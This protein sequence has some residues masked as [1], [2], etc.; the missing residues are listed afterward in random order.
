MPHAI[1][2]FRPRGYP[3]VRHSPSHIN[4]G[5]AH[6]QW[7]IQVL[8]RNPVCQCGQPATQAHHIKALVDGGDPFTLANGAAL[9]VSCHSKI[10]YAENH[11]NN[12]LKGE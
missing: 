12:N 6:R 5:H 1:R 9:C 4:Y 3:P 8:L 10:T 2:M 11:K 7:R